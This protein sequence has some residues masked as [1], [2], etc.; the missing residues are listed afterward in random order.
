MAA[1]FLPLTKRPRPSKSAQRRSCASAPEAST[2]AASTATASSALMGCRKS[3]EILAMRES[4]SRV[5]PQDH[6]LRPCPRELVG[7]GS[8]KSRA[9]IYPRDDG[10]P[11]GQLSPSHVHACHAATQRALIPLHAA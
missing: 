9:S 6:E 2:V 5:H 7:N 10:D 8:S 3:P 4:T 1:R 11:S